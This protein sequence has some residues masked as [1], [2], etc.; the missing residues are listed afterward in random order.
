MTDLKI[1]LQAHSAVHLQYIFVENATIPQILSCSALSLYLITVPV[2]NCRLFSD[3]DISQG[4]VVTRL[5]CGEIFSYPF[6]ANL[7]QNLTVKEY[8][9]SVKIW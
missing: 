8:W 7:S 6:T 4:S 3:I 5:R 9:K 2:S 1:L